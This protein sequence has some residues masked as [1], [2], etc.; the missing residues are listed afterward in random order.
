MYLIQIMLPLYDNRGH[1]LPGRLFDATSRTLA[2]AHGGVTAY[3][4][5]PAVGVWNS[6]GA[7]L[8][9]DDIVVFEVM[10]PSLSAKLWA[11]RRKIWEVVFRQETILIRSLRCRKI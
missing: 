6:R 10:T 9:R 7:R 11:R 5:S 4:R 3:T 8:K 1:R 2:K